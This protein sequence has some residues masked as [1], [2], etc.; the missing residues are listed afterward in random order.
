ME[1]KIRYRLYVLNPESKK[2]NVGATGKTLENVAK[3]MAL[4][5]MFNKDWYTD[6]NGKR[7]KLRLVC[8]KVKG[9]DIK[10]LEEYKITKNWQIKGYFNWEKIGQ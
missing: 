1:S 4:N 7:L 3:K 8:E 2:W 9:K 10:E 5:I 6:G